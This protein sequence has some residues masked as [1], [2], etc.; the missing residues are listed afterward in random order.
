MDFKNEIVVLGL[1]FLMAFKDKVAECGESQMHGL[2]HDASTLGGPE[3]SQQ[4]PSLKSVPIQ[5]L[6]PLLAN[7]EPLVHEKCLS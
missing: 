4:A 5:D 1:C 6:K 3:F 7:T 2:C